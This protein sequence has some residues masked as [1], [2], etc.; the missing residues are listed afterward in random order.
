M[1]CVSL[2]AVTQFNRTLYPNGVRIYKPLTDKSA[3]RVDIGA[4]TDGVPFGVG[5]AYDGGQLSFSWS[6]NSRPSRVDGS[7]A[8]V[9]ITPSFSN[10]DMDPTLDV[11]VSV[12]P[13]GQ[14][15]QSSTA[16]LTLLG[17]HTHTHTL[18]YNILHRPSNDY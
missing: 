14:I 8:V 9:A 12:N 18:N 10:D 4:D 3:P 5:V 15:T 16:I 7:G 2:P 11:R 6:V 13:E 17:Q 1:L